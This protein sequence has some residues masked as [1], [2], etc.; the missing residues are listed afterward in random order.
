MREPQFPIHCKKCPDY[1][2]SLW[3]R[4]R[5]TNPCYTEHCYCFHCPICSSTVA[6]CPF[7][8]PKK[9]FDF[10][11]GVLNQNYGVGKIVPLIEEKRSLL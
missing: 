7:N 3:K 1:K 4:M 11:E 6:R 5:E 8:M 9:D 2:P 10:L